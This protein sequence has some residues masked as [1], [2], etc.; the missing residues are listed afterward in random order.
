MNISITNNMNVQKKHDPELTAHE[1]TLGAVIHDELPSKTIR[2]LMIAPTPFYSGRGT[3]MRIFHEA[4]ALANRGHKIYIVTYHIGDK[5]PHKHPNI[6]VKRINRILFWYTKR[7]SGP[8]W[9]K[10]FLDLLLFIKVLRISI[11]KK[12][13][14]LHGHLHEG[15]LIGWIVKKFLFYRKIVLI[16]DFHG[17]LVDE[18]R[19]HGYLRF[20]MI[21]KIFALIEK[22]ITRMPSCV[23]VSS[24]GLKQVMDACRKAPDVC[25]LSDAPTLAYRLKHAETS[26]GIPSNPDLPSVVYTGGFTPDKGLEHLVEV[27]LYSMKNNLPCR[28]IIAGGP[29]KMLSIPPDIQSAVTVVSPLNQKKLSELLQH[30]D[31]ACDPKREEI[32][33]GSG[34][35]LNYMYAGLPL[36]CFDG[37]AQ[38]FYLGDEL[39]SMLIAKD[40]HQ[41]YDIIKKLLSLSVAEKQKLKDKILNQSKQFTWSQSA[42]TLEQHYIRQWQIEHK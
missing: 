8:N 41:F 12:P 30:A 6:T 25:V 37:P 18:M 27:I 11:K 35:L 15:V 38:R 26:V 33:Q 39:A 7:S 17:P 13:E 21:Q 34:K 16:G 4:E 28:W 22:L 42:R 3:H 2:V 23:F 36:V 31:I 40:T 20:S 1:K 14:I 5:P 32:L 19:S 29:L 24:P 9:Q 10:I